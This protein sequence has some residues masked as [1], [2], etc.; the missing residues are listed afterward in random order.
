MLEFCLQCVGFL[1]A[2]CNFFVCSVLGFVCSVREFR[3]QRV[4]VLLAA[5]NSFVWSVLKFCLQSAGVLF[6]P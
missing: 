4:I 2:S 3:L 5:C 6:A 1:F